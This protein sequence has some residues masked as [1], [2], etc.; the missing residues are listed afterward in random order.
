MP[1]RGLS[2]AFHEFPT[3]YE[4]VGVGQPHKVSQVAR[5]VS[6]SRTNSCEET[7]PQSPFPRLLKFV[8]VRGQK[9]ALKFLR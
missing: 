9:V 6:G 8:V 1:E 2:G 3:S 4:F 5:F 7:A